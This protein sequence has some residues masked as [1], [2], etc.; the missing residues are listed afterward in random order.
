LWGPPT[1]TNPP[2]CHETAGTSGGTVL[3]CDQRGDHQ[4][5]HDPFD[6]LW[7]KADGDD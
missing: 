3:I 2:H 6:R 7:W 1:S 5:H 4:L